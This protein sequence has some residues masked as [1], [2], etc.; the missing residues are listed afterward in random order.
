LCVGVVG[1]LFVCVHLIPLSSLAP[2]T[3]TRVYI[4]IQLQ[5]QFFDTARRVTARR[6]TALIFYTILQKGDHLHT[7]ECKVNLLNVF[8]TIIDFNLENREGKNKQ[9]DI[10][11]RSS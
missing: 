2:I 7:Y 8:E 9:G 10:F 4:N 6:V 5:L 11:V 3:C 1:F